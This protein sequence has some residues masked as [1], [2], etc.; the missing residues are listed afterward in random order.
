VLNYKKPRLWIIVVLIIIVTAIGIG[1]ATNPKVR[2]SDELEE[3]KSMAWEDISETDE[4]SR[5]V[6]ENLEIIM[7]SPGESS[8][9]YAYI[10][11]HQDKYEN[12]K[13]IGGEEA[14]QYML[15]QFESGNVD[16]LRGVIMMQ[17]C[18]E[19]LGVR[20]NVTDETLTPMEWYSALS[21]RQEVKLPDF[22]YDGNDLTEKLVYATEIEKNSEPQRGFTIVAPKIFGSL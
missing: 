21:V 20:N 16:G 10:Q 9:P 19:L 5:L 1:L 6:E 18:K 8:N 3:I 15:L 12:I 17:L 22:S 2:E 13:K 4:V 14:L 7:S 11:A